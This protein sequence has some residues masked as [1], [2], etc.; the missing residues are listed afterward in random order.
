MVNSAQS[1]AIPTTAREF[2]RWLIQQSPL[3]PPEIHGLGVRAQLALKSMDQKA[4]AQ[5]E[6]LQRESAKDL[7]AFATAYAEWKR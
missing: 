6:A 4:F 5:S 2:E 3:L 7:Q 1:N